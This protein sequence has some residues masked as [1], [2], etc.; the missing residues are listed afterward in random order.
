MATVL[1]FGLLVPGLGNALAEEAPATDGVCFLV[2]LDGQ[3][4]ATAGGAMALADMTVCYRALPAEFWSPS[5]PVLKAQATT[6]TAASRPAPAD[7]GADSV[8]VARPDPT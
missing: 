3:S 7:A 5:A 8:T 1:V 6:P 2:S 4:T